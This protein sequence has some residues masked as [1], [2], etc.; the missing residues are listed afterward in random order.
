MPRRLAWGRMPQHRTGMSFMPFGRTPPL[1]CLRI[2][3]GWHAL[4][5]RRAWFAGHALR[6]LRACHTLLGLSLVMIA[7]CAATGTSEK[8]FSFVDRLVSPTGDL[9]S[10]AVQLEIA[11]IR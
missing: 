9:G 7:G 5:L 4:S 10:N 11:Q 2:I 3:L 6:R 8:K 1:A